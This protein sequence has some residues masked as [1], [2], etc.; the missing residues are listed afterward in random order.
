MLRSIRA[1]PQFERDAK[2]LRRK[3]YDLALLERA[4]TAIFEEDVSALRSLRDHALK[5]S[6]N[7]YRE[8]HV[9]GD[10]LVIYRIDHDVLELVLTRTGSHDDLF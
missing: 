4:V 3:H 8:L 5:G 6:W 7:G 9:Q 2:R 10:W 1:T